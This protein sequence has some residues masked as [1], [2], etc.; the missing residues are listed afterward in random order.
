MILSRLFLSLSSTSFPQYNFWP[1][2]HHQLSHPNNCFGLGHHHR[3][4]M[5]IIGKVLRETGSRYRFPSA[6]LGSLRR[7]WE[8]RK[9]IRYRPDNREEE[10]KLENRQ[11]SFDVTSF[12]Q[13]GVLFLKT[14][15]S[16]LQGQICSDF[17]QIEMNVWSINCNHDN[18]VFHWF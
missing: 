16:R 3:T 17:V 9:T 13:R 15:L 12:C 1:H 6:F 8:K 2:H 7:I 4:V 11:K 14:S 10:E 5:K 18:A